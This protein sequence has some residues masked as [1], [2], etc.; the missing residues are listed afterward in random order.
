MDD[1][2][3]GD[4][5]VMPRVYTRSSPSA[6]PVGGRLVPVTLCT[7]FLPPWESKC[8]YSLTEL[9]HYCNLEKCGMSDV[10]SRILRD[11]GAEL[12]IKARKPGRM[13]SLLQPP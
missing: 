1:G 3:G 13:G 12:F 6:L 7:C 2:G 11:T 4:R 10:P 8:F 9:S 5:C